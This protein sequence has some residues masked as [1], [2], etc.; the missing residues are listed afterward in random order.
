M[1]ATPRLFLVGCLLIVGGF[2]LGI[3]LAREAWPT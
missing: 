2:G 3:W 1:T